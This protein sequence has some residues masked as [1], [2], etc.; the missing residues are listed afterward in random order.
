LN[1]VHAKFE[2]EPLC[3][4]CKEIIFESNALTQPIVQ[5][6]AHVQEQQKGVSLLEVIKAENKIEQIEIDQHLAVDSNDITIGGVFANGVFAVSSLVS[7][8][9]RLRVFQTAN[10]EEI[11]L[12]SSS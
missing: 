5:R 8:A 2:I 11:E 4:K 12:Q 6:S 9:N 1:S 7:R 10:Y 3:E